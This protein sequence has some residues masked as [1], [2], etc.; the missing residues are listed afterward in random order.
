[1]SKK[2]KNKEKKNYRLYAAAGGICVLLFALILA[3]FVFRGGNAG[4]Q[5]LPPEPGSVLSEPVDLSALADFRKRDQKLI[6]ALLSEKDKERKKDTAVRQLEALAPLYLAWSDQYAKAEGSIK[7]YGPRAAAWLNEILWAMMQREDILHGLG[8]NWTSQP[9]KER[10]PKADYWACVGGL[11][12]NPYLWSVFEK[13]RGDDVL[14]IPESEAREKVISALK[15]IKYP[16][17]NGVFSGVEIYVLPSH[18]MFDEDTTFGKCAVGRTTGK[19]YTPEDNDRFYNGPKQ[20]R[21]V[22]AGIENTNKENISHELAHAWFRL[23]QNHGGKGILVAWAECRKPYVPARI[24]PE[25]LSDDYKAAGAWGERPE[26]VM[27]ED[28]V[29][30]FASAKQSE[31]R[32]E[33][34]EVKDPLVL[35]RLKRFFEG[36]VTNES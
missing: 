21:V 18:G 5:P 29:Y 20:V 28:F 27:A 12:G 3:I 7:V 32:H 26:E 31:T 6:E 35:S 23:M 33:W 36:E 15:G 1:M 16:F 14:R 9:P 25:N 24:D 22:I 8:R 17:S 11:D 30:L 2:G 4:G 34:P 19:G 10:A 13:G